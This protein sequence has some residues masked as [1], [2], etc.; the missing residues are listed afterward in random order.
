MKPLLKALRGE[1]LPRPPIW[2]M[3]QAGRYL[4]EYRALRT[5][6]K[7]F[8]DLALNPELA[9]EVTLQPIR[10][11]GMDGAILFADI[12][13]VP[14]ALGQKLEFLAGEGPQLEPI[15]DAA[16]L[17]K[18]SDAR[19][20]DILAPVMQTV[21]GVRAA[22]PPE[23][24]LI[25][26]AG[27][28]WTVATYMIEGRGKTEYENCRRMLWSEPK[29]FA[30]IMDLLVDSTAA[31]LNAQAEA[32]AEALK[33][34][35]S[36]AGAVPAPLFDVAVIAPTARIVKAVKAKH[37]NIPII[38]LPRGAGSHVA[39]YAAETGVDAVAI[40]HMTDMAS[41]ILPPGVVPQGNLD[42]MLLMVG[43]APMEAE[44]RRILASMKGR[45]FIFNL[46]HG[47]LQHTPPEH[48]AR[49]VE[50]VKG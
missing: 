10:R 1:A 37:P 6:A 31:Y 2:L 16:G 30:S 50:V 3:R 9:V 42:P 40:D 14:H 26:F 49:L 15:R 32:G 24:T 29:L 4:P 27:A 39:R 28:P 25:G 23:V 43:G 19:A 21:K 17:A 45:P 47:V 36:W 48:I 22:L 38:G 8:V 41:V 11:F 7:S 44:A 34:F 13:L 46:G 33:I 20:A 35:D 5:K 12:L 18:L